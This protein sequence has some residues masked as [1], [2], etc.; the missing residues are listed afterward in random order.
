MQFSKFG[1]KFTA[2]SGIVQ[3]MDDLGTAMAGD[4]P[5]LMLGGGNPG[6]NPEIDDTVRTLLANIANDESEYSR[7]LGA[8]AGP[9]GELKF[10]RSLVKLLNKTFNWQL[11]EDNIAITN[12]S[13]NAFFYLFNLFGGEYSN[14]KRKKILLPLAPEYIGYGDAFVE[15]QH[16]IANKPIIEEL[17]DG[18]FKYRV[19]FDQLTITDEIGAICVSRP[20][21]PTGN[22]LT[23]NEIEKLDQIA[24][25]HDIPL[26]I[27]GA[28]G[29]PFPEIIFA[30]VKPMWNDN[31]I[32]CLSLSK[33]GM[34]GVRTGIVI[35]HPDI[36]HAIGC[37]NGIINL[38]P[39][40]LGPA[41]TEPLI[42]SGEIL[43]L[44]KNAVK[45]FYEKKVQQAVGWV[46]N[47]MADQPVFI[48]KPEGALFLWLWFKDLPIT[49]QTLYERLKARRVLILPSH[50]FYPG[51]DEE[52]QHKHECIR[53]TYSQSEETVREGIK[54][55]AE[56]VA[57]AYAE[58]GM[59]TTD[60]R[61]PL[62]A[63]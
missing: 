27:D 44:S 10:I 58:A 63:L 43:S 31:T 15:G 23:D 26:I 57:K 32:I 16:F 51:L 30:D 46:K 17:D 9:N 62:A 40:S 34:P 33:F 36:I 24:R 39:N 56:E 49:T 7:I 45:P 55:I 2:P 25:A 5:M 3:L 35:A 48:H 28:Y 18:F 54:I 4:E 29:T 13:Q 8:Y 14:G 42:A 20:T 37:L 19:D 61:E 59:S 22:V 38:A 52:W 53:L 6:I 12:G 41:I 60:A 1:D 21:N 47:Y 11:T 50:Y